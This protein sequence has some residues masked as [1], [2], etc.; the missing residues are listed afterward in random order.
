MIGSSSRSLILTSASFR[1]KFG[2]ETSHDFR[3]AFIP[4][5]PD[6]AALRKR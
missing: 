5:Q 6:K 2:L 4:E 1:L 3:L